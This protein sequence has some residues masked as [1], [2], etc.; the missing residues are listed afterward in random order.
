MSALLDDELVGALGV[1]VP[2]P[3]VLEGV[4]LGAGY[5]IPVDTIP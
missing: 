1:E 4:N 3:C 2:L 5:R